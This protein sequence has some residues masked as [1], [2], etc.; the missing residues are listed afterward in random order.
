MTVLWDQYFLRRDMIRKQREGRVRGRLNTTARKLIRRIARIDAGLPQVVDLF[1]DVGAW[2]SWMPGIT[3]SRVLTKS[4]AETVRAKVAQ[5]GFGRAWANTI[6]VRFV[7]DKVRVH[8]VEGLFRWRADWSF[9]KPPGDEGTTVSLEL[10]VE[11]GLLS[12]AFR[13]PFFKMSERRFDET[14]AVI[15]QQARRRQTPETRPAAGRTLLVVYETAD[16]LEVWYRGRRYVN[17]ERG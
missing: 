9:L 17:R 2:E 12:T 4:G 15:A 5:S 11:P 6:E 3:R 16:G 10:E 1:R 7:G 14:V 8:A 13:R